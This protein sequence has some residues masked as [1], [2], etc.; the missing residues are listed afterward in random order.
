MLSRR[1]H[2]VGVRRRLHDL[3]G[4]RHHTCTRIRRRRDSIRVRARRCHWFRRGTQSIVRHARTECIDLIID[5]RIGFFTPFGF[6]FFFVDAVI[7][8]LLRDHSDL[9]QRFNVQPRTG[10]SIDSLCS[11]HII[12]PSAS[13][14]RLV[15]KCT[16]PIVH[17]NHM[18]HHCLG[19]DLAQDLTGLLVKHPHGHKVD[20]FMV[21]EL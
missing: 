20:L 19:R 11:C 2:E 21:L 17:L 14:C 4:V 6:D 13:L 18:F 16:D 1:R 15:Q 3:D 7:F 9:D 8:L 12:S 5:V 10:K